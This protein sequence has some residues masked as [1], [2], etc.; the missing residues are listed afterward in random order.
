MQAGAA[1][2]TADYFNAVSVLEKTLSEKGFRD[3]LREDFLIPSFGE[4]NAFLYAKKK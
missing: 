2:T 3:I 4:K 1:K